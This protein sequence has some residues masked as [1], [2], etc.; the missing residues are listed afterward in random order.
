MEA[1]PGGGGVGFL[2]AVDDSSQRVEDTARDN[3][4]HDGG[5]ASCPQLRQVPDGD[6]AE[7]DVHEGAEPA[8]CGGPEEVEEDADDRAS[9]DD[10]QE[11]RGVGAAEERDGQRRVSARDEQEDVGVIQPLPHD[12]PAWGPV[13]AVVG[14]GDAEENEGACQ[15]DGR[16][17]FGR[18]RGGQAHEHDGCGQRQGGGCQVEP[19]AQLRLDLDE[20]SG[21]PLLGRERCDFHLFTSS[22]SYATVGY[23]G[24]N[25]GVWPVLALRE[26]FCFPVTNGAI[27][28]LL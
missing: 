12:L 18:G 21:R 19:A 27:P 1:E 2:R 3:E 20:L 5:A 22:I 26:Y 15:I 25:S 24:V 23:Y 10:G 14:C 28:L 6:P 13:E 7:G 16:P 9:P 17:D 4:P 11:D 8:R